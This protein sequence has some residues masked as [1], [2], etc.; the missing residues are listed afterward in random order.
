MVGITRT[1]DATCAANATA[2]AKF[3]TDLSKN[4]IASENCGAEF[5][6]NDP[7][8]VDTYNAMRAYLP[9]YSASCLRDPETNAYCYASAV[10]NMTSPANTYVYFL[11]LNQSLPGS[12]IPACN[13]CLQQTMAIYQDATADRNQLI[14]LTYVS[15]AKQINTI[16][17]PAFVN[18]SL[19]EEITSFAHRVLGDMKS[20]SLTTILS[21]FVAALW[22]I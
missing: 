11:P 7:A 12:S 9:I 13:W 1:L 2:C 10:T 15:A 4:L 6:A 19:A 20:V 14:S 5:Q 17:G 16:C 18:E 8:I 22:L 3:M 21:A